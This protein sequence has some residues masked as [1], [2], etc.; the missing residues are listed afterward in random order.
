MS[1]RLPGLAP[2]VRS[3][4]RVVVLGS[5]PG[6]AS[7]AAGAYYA[8]PRN[9]FW[10]ILAEVCGVPFPSLPYA[11]RVERLLDA[12][13]GLWDVYASCERAGSLDSAIRRAEPNDLAVLTRA[14]PGLSAIVHNGAESARH[15]RA[16]AA[17]GLPV[18]RAP[19]TSPANAT[20][21]F[22]RKVDAWR[23]ALA[24]IFPIRLTRI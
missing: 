20:W 7:L 11:A 18:V 23:H 4:T 1:V 3:D 8:H 9:H 10:P 24:P 22:A 6:A 17:L 15:A 5:F 21:S 13:V 16:L 12:G 14:A 19:S 2:V